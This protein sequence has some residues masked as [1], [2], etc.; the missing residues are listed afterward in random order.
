MLNEN[1]FKV[2]YQRS[3]TKFFFL[4]SIDGENTLI[5]GPNNYLYSGSHEF[6][7]MIIESSNVNSIGCTKNFQYKYYKLVTADI[8]FN[9][10]DDNGGVYLSERGISDVRDDKITYI[11]KK[12]GVKRLC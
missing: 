4:K 1:N 9:E 12:D 8:T 6:E 3:I 5:V 10:F 7:A 11:L 2:A